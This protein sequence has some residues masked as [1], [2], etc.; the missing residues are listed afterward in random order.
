[1]VSKYDVTVHLSGEDGN[2]FSLL[3]SCRRSLRQA[4]VPDKEID[5]FTAEVMDSPNY[6][7]ALRVMMRWVDVS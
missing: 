1:M 5:A 7:A 3:G 6:D 2:L 4:E